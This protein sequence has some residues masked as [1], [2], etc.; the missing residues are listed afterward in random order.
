MP[1]LAG[2]ETCL[3]SYLKFEILNIAHSHLCG[4]LCRRYEIF[5]FSKPVHPVAVATYPLV[6]FYQQKFAQDSTAAVLKGLGAAGSN[7]KKELRSSG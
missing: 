2:I 4:W 3:T 1:K 6:R 7:N 5:T